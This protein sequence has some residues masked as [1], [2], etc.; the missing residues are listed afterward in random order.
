[1][2]ASKTERRKREQTVQATDLCRQK[3][4]GYSESF[5]ELAR[6]FGGSLPI[7]GES[8]S[9]NG[10]SPC[11]NGGSRSMDRQSLLEE[12]KNWENR[13]VLCDN[14]SEMAEIMDRVAREEITYEPMEAQKE[15]LISRALR[16]EALCAEH[17]CY[18]PC[19]NGR[20]AIGM[21]LS[22]VRRGGCP[23]EEVADILSVLL[24]TQFQV[25]AVSPYL[26]EQKK[27]SFLFMEQAKYIVLS[28]FARAIRE[29]EQVSGDNYAFL[30]SEKGKKTILLSDGTGSGEKANED[31]GNVLD[32]MEKML[33][34]GY[35][36]TAAVNLINS[37]LYAKDEDSNH[38]TL[39]ICDL[40]LHLGKCR[41]L[42]V[43]GAASFLKRGKRVEEIQVGNLP[44]GIFR[45]IQVQEIPN[46]LQNGDYL[47]M[48][49]DGV[50]DAFG[51]EG[52]D[53]ILQEII[54][55]ITE[56][57]PGEIAEI[58]LQTAIHR[59]EGRIYDDMTIVV[60]GIWENSCIT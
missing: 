21:T 54:A 19:E 22:T 38:P 36:G 48:M 6:S 50:L 1:M 28:G 46:T 60:A 59:S 53:E 41:F 13:K 42:K 51:E 30:E 43:G 34:A 14:L 57:N 11:M 20:T 12:R 10:D 58:L 39:D 37:A 16:E 7:N 2:I 5:R 18:V 45:H 8:F 3:L 24:H 15:H 31:S 35:T 47:I 44:L 27:H 17:L 55:E 29:N 52:G 40:D 49:T 23:A 32:L 25:S 26:V 33:E 9:V 4:L 56:Q